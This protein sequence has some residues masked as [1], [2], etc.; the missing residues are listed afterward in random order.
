[1]QR[2]TEL[3]AVANVVTE[4][5]EKRAL[6]KLGASCMTLQ[7]T[8]DLLQLH[9]LMCRSCLRRLVEKKVEEEDTNIPESWQSFLCYVGAA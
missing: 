5:R 6:A 2:G 9:L 3:E 8:E 1:M 7:G 4:G